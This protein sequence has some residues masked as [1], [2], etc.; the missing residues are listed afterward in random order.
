MGYTVKHG[1]SIHGHYET[2]EA[3]YDA[4]RDE[5]CNQQMPKL[6]HTSTHGDEHYHWESGIISVLVDP[7]SRS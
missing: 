2:K 1:M 7:P 3:A 5:I 6:V 4:I